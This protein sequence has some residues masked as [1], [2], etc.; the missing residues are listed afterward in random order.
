[1]QIIARFYSSCNILST[2]KRIFFKLV[3]ITFCRLLQFISNDLKSKE[4]I[5]NKYLF[6]NNVVVI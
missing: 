3:V 1:M 6:Y 4:L 5:E 2:I